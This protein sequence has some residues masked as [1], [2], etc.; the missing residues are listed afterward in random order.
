MTEHKTNEGDRKTLA[1]LIEFWDSQPPSNPMYSDRNEV[2]PRSKDKL[3]VGIAG[4]LIV[5]FQIRSQVFDAKVNENQLLILLD[6]Y[7]ARSKL[8]WLSVSSVCYGSGAS[9]TTALRYIEALERY[10]YIKRKPFNS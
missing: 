10:N 6:M 9:S 5:D 2:R 8:S 7:V 4:S 3:Y 1:E